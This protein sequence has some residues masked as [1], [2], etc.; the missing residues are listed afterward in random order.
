MID[1]QGRTASAFCE[2]Y[3]AR[4]DGQKFLS[5]SSQTGFKSCMFMPYAS[6]MLLDRLLMLKDLILHPL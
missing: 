5:F 1:D 3:R 2:H 6:I 4:Q